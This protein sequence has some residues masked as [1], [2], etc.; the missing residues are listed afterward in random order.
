MSY[1][2]KVIEVAGRDSLV[3]RWKDPVTGL[4][5]QKQAGTMNRRTAQRAAARLETQIAAGQVDGG[6]LKWSDFRDA[7]EVEHLSGLA[8]RS[9]QAACTAMNRLEKHCN[10]RRLS[11]VTSAMLSTFA[12]RLRADGAKETT[13]ASYLGQIRAA[14]GWARQT[15]RIAVVPMIVKPQR[16][17]GR[18]SVMRGRPITGE[19]L[20]RMVAHTAD[21]REHDAPE[22]ERY[23]KGLWLSGLRLGES[24]VLSWDDDTPLSVDLSGKHP[25]LRIWQEGEKAHRDRFLPITPDF[26]TFLLET[27]LPA[28]HGL[29]FRLPGRGEQMTVKRVS[30]YVSAIGKAAKVVTNKADKKFATAHDLRRSFGTRWAQRVMPAVLQQLMRHAA[31]ETTMKYYVGLDA[32]RLASDLWRDWPESPEGDKSGDKKTVT[33]NEA[34]TEVESQ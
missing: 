31:I 16:S 10:P 29:V 34:S 3:L 27:P 25:R 24:L 33:E 30:R 22:W 15:R 7:Y 4:W 14:L 9:M 17:R 26:A 19:E 13:I 5:R 2:V 11:T 1:R 8:K 28:R 12:S 23:L 20:D 32:D 18:N 21:V 6:D